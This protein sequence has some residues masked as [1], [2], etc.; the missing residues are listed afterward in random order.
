MPTSLLKHR[1]CD[2]KS[3]Q[4]PALSQLYRDTDRATTGHQYHKHQSEE[5]SKSDEEELQSA[6]LSFCPCHGTPHCRYLPMRLLGRDNTIGAAV[7]LPSR[8][9][10]HAGNE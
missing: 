3:G 10:G 7:G 9:H 5:A 2:Q 8:E 4:T 1:D 6:W